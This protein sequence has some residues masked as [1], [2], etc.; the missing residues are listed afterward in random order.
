MSHGPLSKVAE[1]DR[2]FE[3]FLRLLPALM[4]EHEG[5]YVL[6]RHGEI[7]GSHATP[8]D[9][10]IAGN[11][12]FPDDGLFSFQHVTETPG[13]LGHFSYAVSSRTA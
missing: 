6:M 7:V 3:R 13:S 9:A 8:A 1:I 4:R 5:D 2:N 11:Q 10:Q 12:L